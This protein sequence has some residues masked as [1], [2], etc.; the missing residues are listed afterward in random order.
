MVGKCWLSSMLTIFLLGWSACST[1][2]WELV[3]TD[4][5]SD[6][7]P[8]ESLTFS[9]DG[10]GWSLTPGEL[11]RF[12]KGNWTTVLSNQNNERVFYSF[13]FSS[14][15]HGIV[16]GGQKKNGLY[17]V[18]ILQTTDGG[19]T[20]QERPTDVKGDPDIHNMSLLQSISLCG[21][22]GWAVGQN[23][24]LHTSDDGQTWQRQRWNTGKEGVDT[25]LGTVT[26]TSSLR[27]WAAGADG[28][29]LRTIDGGNSW[30]QQDVGTTDILMRVRF[31]GDTGW[32]V[33]GTHGKAVILNTRDHGETWQAQQTD[34]T[35]GL[36][37]VFFT[38]SKGWL[39]GET[40]TIL[41]TE[42][43][44]LTWTRQESPTVE[45]L[46]CIFFLSPNKGWA[47]GDKRTLLRF[48]D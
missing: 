44:G 28:L 38:G 33:G 35:K 42:D 12:T 37:D 41:K 43:G 23:L 8:I 9:K 27:A 10:Q 29:V 26:C 46:T 39:V 24:I 18:L 4:H 47:G 22:S 34:L 45:N 21:T 11:L 25:R 15:L 7:V 48:S 20:W 36:L 32:I 14:D 2:K 17:T 30:T 31:F 6:G 40:G 16:V 5:I 13:V 1:G 19:V 3:S